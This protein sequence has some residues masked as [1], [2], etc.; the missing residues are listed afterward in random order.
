MG[1]RGLW[2]YNSYNM[3]QLH[4]TK[5]IMVGNSLG[6]ILPKNI[7]DAINLQRGDQVYFLINEDSSITIKKINTIKIS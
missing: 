2:Y 1:G 4:I 6:V 5:V 3:E 7:L